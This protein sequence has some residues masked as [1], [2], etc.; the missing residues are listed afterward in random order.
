MDLRWNTI[1]ILAMA[2]RYAIQNLIVSYLRCKAL[3]V[4]GMGLKVT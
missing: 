3:S 1:H 2:L 4:I